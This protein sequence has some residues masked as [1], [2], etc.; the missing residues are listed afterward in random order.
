MK[1]Y[2]ITG[3]SSDV[4]ICYIKSLEEKKETVT[5]YA[6]Y[7]TNCNQLCELKNI[8]EYVKVITIQADL[9]DKASIDNMLDIVKKENITNIIHLAASKFEYMRFK[10][11]DDNLFEYEMQV[12]LKS[13]I[14]I[15]KE[16][17]PIMSKE[18]YGRIVIMLTAYT[19]GKVPKFMSHYIVIKHALIG[20]IKSISVEYA[21]KGI[22]INGISP[23]MMETKFLANI[24]ERS[25]EIAAK[26]ST[27]ERN[28]DLKEVCST[29]EF[30]M[31]DNASYITGINMNVSGGDYM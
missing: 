16:L 9:S 22:N 30:L 29:I 17:L 26:N 4:G 12:Q 25:I 24:D 10:D 2:L 21:K 31:S 18:K 23:N 15:L 13:I 27:L 20:L 7:N 3:A 11:F 5:V 28:V 8:C 6:H 1:T 19:L 14:H